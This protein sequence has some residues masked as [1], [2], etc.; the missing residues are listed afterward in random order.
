MDLLELEGVLLRRAV[1]R[2]ATALALLSLFALLL[3]VGAGFM[4]WGFYLYAAKALGQ[5]AGAFLTGLVF[6]LLSGALLWTARK[7]VR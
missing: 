5:P 3:A 4:V 7:L 6:L 2:L 1:L